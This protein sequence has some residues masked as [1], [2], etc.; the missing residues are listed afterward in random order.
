M[1]QVG[2]G[3]NAGLTGRIGVG[4]GKSGAGSM[5]KDYGGQ[6]GGGK[7]LAREALVLGDRSHVPR[8]R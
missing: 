2:W 6:W 4:E 7:P 3:I 1:L 8:E 5:G